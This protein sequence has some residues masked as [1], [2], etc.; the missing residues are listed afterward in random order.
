MELLLEVDAHKE[1]SIYSLKQYIEDRKVLLREGQVYL[2][3]EPKITTHTFT[4]QDK[5]DDPF[6]NLPKL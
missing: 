4:V 2:E 5:V 3:E 6:F 1:K